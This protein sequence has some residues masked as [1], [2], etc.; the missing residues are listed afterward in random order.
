LEHSQPLNPWDWIHATRQMD[1]VGWFEAD[2]VNSRTLVEDA[3]VHGARSALDVGGG[4]SRLVDH[5]LDLGLDRVAV[6]DISAAALEIA[7]HRLGDRATEVEW[8]VGDVASTPDVGAFDVWHDRGAF[9]FLLDPAA[10]AAYAD[11]ARRTIPVGGRA[12][13]ATFGDDGPERCSGMPVQRWEP[14]RLA[15]ALGPAFRLTDSQRH[16]HHTPA[17]VPQ[18]FQYSVL[19]RVEG[20]EAAV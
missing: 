13:I 18:R 1:Q 17:G 5:F 7:R 3:V 4:A 15:A 2:P 14:E 6:L 8:L 9:H 10:R 11:L 12:I 19:E 16:V 20:V